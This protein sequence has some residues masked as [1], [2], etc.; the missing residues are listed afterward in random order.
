[1]LNQNLPKEYVLASGEM[2]TIRDFLEKTLSCAE[3]EFT[4][5]G[6]KE[7]E[8][9]ISTYTG[10]SLVEINPK[11]YRPAEVH[12]L[13]GDPSLAE[14]EFNWKR[15]TDFNGLVKKMYKNDYA[16]LS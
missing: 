5:I 4:K 13:C 7:K 2:H 15:K 8:K 12:S 10:K 11:F 3:I 14:K 6:S 16:L 1:M 9:Y